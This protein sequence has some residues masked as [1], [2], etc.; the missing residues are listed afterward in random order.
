MKAIKTSILF[1]AL[2]IATAAVAQT[3]DTYVV[4]Q[5]GA[6]G[7]GQMI[8]ATGTIKA[9]DQKTREVTIT[10]QQGREFVVTAGP[11][12]KN[13]AQLK[14]GDRVDVHYAEALLVELKKGGGAVV[15]RTEQAGV[16]SAAPGSMPGAMVGRQVK[17]VGDVV[18]VDPAKQTVTVRGAQHTIDVNIRDPEQFKRIAVGDQLEA[19][20]FEAAAVDVS[21]A[22]S[23]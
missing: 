19:T 10:G 8:S 12:V 21:P 23:Q 14:V 18:K 1:A 7:A 11:E 3:A 6:V 9:I 13:F 5:P 15:G 2:A 22:K 20:Y 17:V 16:A 4:N